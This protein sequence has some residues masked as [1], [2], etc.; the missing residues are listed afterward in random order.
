MEHTLSGFRIV[1]SHDRPSGSVVYSDETDFND[2]ADDTQPENG[3][4]LLEFRRN[5]D[6]NPLSSEEISIEISSANTLVD[7]FAVSSRLAKRLGFNYIH[8]FE[9]SDDGGL[10]K[11]SNTIISNWPVTFASFISGESLLTH[12]EK[13]DRP[14]TGNTAKQF[15]YVTQSS[16]L[17]AGLSA[18]LLK[19]LLDTGLSTGLVCEFANAK[20]SGNGWTAILSGHVHLSDDVCRLAQQLAENTHHRLQSL[21]TG[22]VAIRK[23]SKR[24]MEC[25]IWTAEGKTSSEIGT[26]LGL[27]ENTINN[28]LVSVIKKLGAVNRSHMITLAMRN[29]IIK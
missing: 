13:M 6:D 9:A 17:S 12:A 2:G 4:A 10:P 22:D 25:A 7:L 16:L 19:H 23:L 28:Y 29:G 20:K 1:Y 3:N 26:I 27:S 8:L 21:D 15:V 5:P 18:S 14:A 24:E 11:S